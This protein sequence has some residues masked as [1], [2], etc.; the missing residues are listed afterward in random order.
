MFIWLQIY[1]LFSIP[2]RSPIHFLMLF[3]K[4]VLIGAG[5]KD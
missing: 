2:Q 4:N 5:M 1:D 3:A